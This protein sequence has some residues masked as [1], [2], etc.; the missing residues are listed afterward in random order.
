MKI[1]PAKGN[2]SICFSK[3]TRLIEKAQTHPGEVISEVFNQVFLTDLT[4]DLL[5]AW[6]QAAVTNTQSLY[7]N[8]NTRKILHEFHEHLL[9]LVEALYV[10]T[11]NT[12]AGLANLTDAQLENP[13]GVLNQFFQKFSIEYIRRELADFLEAG[14]SHDGSNTN[15]FT[16]WLAWMSYNHLLCLTEAAYQL[17]LN[18]Y[19]HSMRVRLYIPRN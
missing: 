4:E 15:D 6:L 2:Q 5:P 13:I 8:G 1:I 3:P 17:Y 14:I 18:Q 16:P 12:K 10:I 11:G 9:Q 19:M 7:S